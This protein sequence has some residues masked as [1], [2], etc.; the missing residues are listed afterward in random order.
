MYGYNNIE[1]N[2]SSSTSNYLYN[3]FPITTIT[4]Q[5]LPLVSN[6]PPPPLSIPLVNNNTIEFDSISPLKSEFNCNN[7]SSSS[8]S[9]YG[10]PAT[11]YNTNDPTSLMQRSISSLSLL[12]KNMEGFCP[13]VSSPTGFHDSKTP[14][15]VKKVL[16]TG[17]LQVMH[18]MQYNN[19]RSES[20]LSSESNSIIEGMNKACKYSPQEKK[21]RIERYRTKRNQRNFN[22][23]I[24]YECRK[25][26]ADSRPRIRGRFARN[27]E[28]ERTPQNEYWNQSRLEELGEE[29]D[30]NWIGFLDAYVP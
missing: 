7:N 6:L 4:S 28:I 17:D 15:S 16:S 26:L 22:K 1:E 24:K 13:I 30:E 29:D 27:D 14:S 25:T 21:E 20:P 9:S 18:M 3:H 10:S 8:C 2:I 12:V 5:T 23:K 19:Y 11:S